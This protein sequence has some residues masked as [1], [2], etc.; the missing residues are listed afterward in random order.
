MP[1]NNPFIWKSKPKNTVREC[2]YCGKPIIDMKHPN[3]KYC[4]EW[5][6]NYAYYKRKVERN[7][8][9]W[10]EKICVECGKTFIPHSAKQLCCK[11]SCSGD[12]LRK[13]QRNWYHENKDRLGLVEKYRLAA[14]ERRRKE[15]EKR[16]RNRVEDSHALDIIAVRLPTKTGNFEKYMGT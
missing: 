9:V 14:Q 8:K 1:K 13:W 7:P 5:C 6:R 15:K 2:G 10:E 11:G 3:Q 16:I 4:D 12:H